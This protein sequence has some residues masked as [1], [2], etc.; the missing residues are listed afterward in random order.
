MNPR[1]SAKKT[2]RK[3]PLDPYLYFKR[4]P[5]YEV[6]GALFP[7]RCLKN[8][9]RAKTQ[10]YLHFR[11]LPQ[12][13][14]AILRSLTCKPA[15][16]AEFGVQVH[17]R[18]RLFHKHE[19]DDNYPY[20]L[21][22]TVND[23]PFPV[24]ASIPVFSS[25]WLTGRI[26]LPINILPACS[27]DPSVENKVSVSW[28]SEHGPQYVAGVFLVR[29][30]PVATILDELRQSSMQKATLT[31]ALVEKMVQRETNCDD[32]T[33]TSVDVSLTCPL[34]QKRMQIPCRAIECTH[35]QCFDATSYLEANEARPTWTCPVCGKWADL[36]SLVVDELFVTIVAEA[37]A[38]CDTVVF[39]HD[40]SWTPWAAQ[41]ELSDRGDSASTSANEQHTVIDLT[42][43]FIDLTEDSDGDQ[44]E[45]GYA[46]VCLLPEHANTGY[47]PGE[48][49]STSP[50]PLPPPPLPPLPPPPLP[51]FRIIGDDV[52][53]APDFG[54][55]AN[56]AGNKFDL[57][58]IIL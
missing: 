11:F 55:A 57:R 18:F 14:T 47:G 4:Q 58:R 33:V 46:G 56:G 10:R 52:Y 27:L 1:G 51:P 45:G 53:S 38:D 49:L 20:D 17:L 12:H 26:C 23:Q 31:R 40:G 50:P 24:P 43:E 36:P 3:R 44:A 13:V 22:V 32:V 54:E 28:W 2:G 21:S 6:L 48:T 30:K 34:S 29:K 37:P 5:F 8:G 42:V 41:E 16:R 9:W 25:G 15:S 19:Q 35:L 39:H 7:P